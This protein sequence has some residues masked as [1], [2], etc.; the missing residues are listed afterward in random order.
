[1]VDS[2][3]NEGHSLPPAASEVLVLSKERS[4]SPD[5]VSLSSTS[6]SETNSEELE[7]SQQLSTSQD[8]SDITGGSSVPSNLADSDLSRTLLPRRPLPGGDVAEMD[9]VQ[10]ENPSSLQSSTVLSGEHDDYTG[11]TLTASVQCQLVDKEKLTVSDYESTGLL[12][13]RASNARHNM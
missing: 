3:V 2:P 6:G 10:S 7:T 12:Y 5:L 9:T 13:A 4:L 11:S 8:D 1:M